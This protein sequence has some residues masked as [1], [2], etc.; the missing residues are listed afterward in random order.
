MEVKELMEKAV[1]F[2]GHSCPGLAIGVLVSKYILENGNDFSCRLM[3][4]HIV[5][6]GASVWGNSVKSIAG[7]AMAV[8][9]SSKNSLK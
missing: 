4:V 9:A 1:K 8:S 6:D 5:R 3:V 2:H 7:I